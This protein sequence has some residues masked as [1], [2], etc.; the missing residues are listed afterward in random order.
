MKQES[1]HVKCTLGTQDVD[2]LIVS[3]SPVNTIPSSL[4]TTLSNDA[5][6]GTIK[7]FGYS[8]KSSRQ[9]CGYGASEPLKVVGSFM[10]L[11]KV[12]DA[13]KPSKVEEFF[14]I[15]NAKQ[16]LLGSST[17]KG[18]KLL[19]VGLE[20]NHI[21]MGDQGRPEGKM[22]RFPIIP[23]LQFKFD[24]DQSVLPRKDFRYDIPQSSYKK[25]L[26]GLELH[27]VG[28]LD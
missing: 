12:K 16:A 19:K 6:A 13:A 22:E 5:K 1:N 28:F 7:I 21:K 2:F 9:L 11:I 17:A 18:M 8:N 3:G 15:E 24:I 10:S 23:N 20:V 14:V 25:L 26:N 27:H 4:W